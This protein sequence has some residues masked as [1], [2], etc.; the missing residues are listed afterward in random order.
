MNKIRKQFS[1]LFLIFSIFA[2]SFSYAVEDLEESKDCLTA[3]EL[4]SKYG[5]FQEGDNDLSMYESCGAHLMPNDFRLLSV[6]PSIIDKETFEKISPL[7]ESFGGDSEEMSGYFKDNMPLQ[8]YIEVLLPITMFIIG[9]IALISSIVGENKSKLKG[10]AYTVLFAIL[11]YAGTRAPELAARSWTYATAYYNHLLYSNHDV[12]KNIQRFDSN[13]QLDLKSSIIEDQH[14]QLANFLHITEAINI[15]T[16]NSI[17]SNT[18]GTD[19]KVDFD[20]MYS[21]S[22]DISEPSVAEFFKQN[23]ACLSKDRVETDSDFELN[24]KTW[25][26][27]GIGSKIITGASI[28]DIPYRAEFK[29]GGETKDYNC[30][31][32]RFGLEQSFA[33][34]QNNALNI[35]QNFIQEKTAQNINA[36]TTALEDF[37]SMQSQDLNYMENEFEKVDAAFGGIQQNLTGKLALAFAA[38]KEAQVSKTDFKNTSTYKSLVSD[39]EK[40]ATP[41][42]KYEGQQNFTTTELAEMNALKSFMASFSMLFSEGVEDDV[43]KHRVNGWH[44]IQP[45]VEKTVRMQMAVDCALQDRSNGNGKSM[46]SFKEE[47]AN[48]WN[49][50]DKGIKNSTMTSIGN[51][52]DYACFVLEDG[53]LNASYANPLLIESNKEEIAARA[54]AIEILLSAMT[55]GIL[56][57]TVS[58]NNEMW[59]EAK[60]EYLNKIRPTLHSVSESQLGF[61]K[62]KRDME[63]VYASVEEIYTYDTSVPLKA[64]TDPQ[65]FFNYNRFSDDI[66]TNED[67]FQSI[68]DRKL[69]PYKLDTIFSNTDSDI[70]QASVGGFSWKSIGANKMIRELLSTGSCPILNKDG[71]CLSSLQELNY[72]STNQMIDV[73]IWAVMIQKTIS[74]IRFGGDRIGESADTADHTIIGDV[75]GPQKLLIWLGKGIHGIAVMID[76]TLG[77]V[78]DFIVVIIGLMILAGKLAQ[79]LPLIT[80]LVLTLYQHIYIVVPILLIPI[81]PVIDVTKSVSSSVSGDKSGSLK[82]DGTIMLAK[83]F[84]VRGLIL[85]VAI[86]VFTFINTSPAVGSAVYHLVSSIFN[87]DG[88]IY[89]WIQN[90][91]MS[92]SYI[93]ALFKSIP[94]IN[95]LEAYMLRLLNVETTPTFNETNT[96]VAGLIG[97]GGGRLFSN[98]TRANSMSNVATQKSA[99]IL[100]D[101]INKRVAAYK[102]QNSLNQG[103]KKELDSDD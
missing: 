71:I 77:W 50:M 31:D 95:D 62:M 34:I 86:E 60:I 99:E 18:Y 4:S 75:K 69:E 26:D 52:S 29:N 44:F 1:F 90:M 13:A 12:E 51:G 9:F 14:K 45:F 21:G 64:L 37:K 78:F 91:I 2:T 43:L 67:M 30:G 84:F 33:T 66:V 63:N 20:L 100:G 22:N 38:A 46:F 83:V 55:N 74:L 79:H 8:N 57:A 94:I 76:S 25:S 5:N 10:V 54:Q 81:V 97:F 17:T 89:F 68:N 93:W 85:Y 49:A 11:T 32:S 19:I 56:N 58:N 3:T 15:A 24:F 70:Q 48:R 103:Q 72:T 16:G 80:D 82:F 59:A 27:D 41:V 96:F 102:T 28:L 87:N 88:L 39:F 36:E 7:V 35:A 65:Y 47:Y 73:E 61:L 6:L 92:V 101:G 98:I 42:F 40:I 53:M 23:A